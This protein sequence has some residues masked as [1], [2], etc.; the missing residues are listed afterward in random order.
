MCGR[1][2]W[3]V[4]SPRDC[5]I[6]IRALAGDILLCFWA[7][8]FTL[9]AP[10]S[11]QVCRLITVALFDGLTSPPVEGAG[12]RWREVEDGGGVCVEIL[13]ALFMLQNPDR[14]DGTL[15][16][17]EDFTCLATRQMQA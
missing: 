17:Y 10:L 15:G 7:R 11:T 5:A 13:L 6:R 12:G 8:N 3:L 16:S 1:P 2:A 14:P 9:T 4:C